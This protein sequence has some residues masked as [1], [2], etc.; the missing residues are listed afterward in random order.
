[1]LNYDVLHITIIQKG[2]KSFARRYHYFYDS[3]YTA[4]PLFFNV[5]INPVIAT[6]NFFYVQLKSHNIMHF[7]YR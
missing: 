6:F 4:D 2:L 5:N 7:L 1:M 3:E